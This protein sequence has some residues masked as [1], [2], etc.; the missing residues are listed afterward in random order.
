MAVGDSKD[1]ERR[2]SKKRNDIGGGNVELGPGGRRT[3]GNIT[4]IKQHGA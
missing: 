1:G 2:P 4:R 3:A